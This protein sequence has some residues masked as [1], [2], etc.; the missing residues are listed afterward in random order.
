MDG[1]RRPRGGDQARDLWPLELV[2][3]AFAPDVQ[4]Q[5]VSLRYGQV[6]GPAPVLSSR[7]LGRGGGGSSRWRKSAKEVTVG[8][9]ETMRRWW[10]QLREG[11][12]VVPAS[13]RTA[14]DEGWWRADGTV[15][16]EGSTMRSTASIRGELPRLLSRRK[17][18]SVLDAPCGDFAWMSTVELGLVE[19]VGVD[20][21]A[22]LIA[23][24]RRRY[25]R[26]GVGFECADITEDRLPVAD[27]V[28]CRDCWIHLPFFR[29]RRSLKQF[30]R[31]GAKW[32]LISDSSSTTV[33]RD[34][35]TG[36]FRPINLRLPPFRFPEPEETLDDG[37][38]ELR[39]YR[40]KDLPS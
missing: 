19:Y 30:H 26:I 28:L 25:G 38:R 22:S 34:V 36:G 11:S 2:L 13:F 32:L 9:R 29:C 37:G 17:V 6:G 35:W 16:G 10:I 33:N 15:C 20:V 27:L 3:P 21:V 1:G 7:T 12:G 14:I 24:N 39:L 31:T 5:A 18:S 23:E 8:L 4:H 40:L